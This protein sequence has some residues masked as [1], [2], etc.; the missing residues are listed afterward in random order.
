MSNKKALNFYEVLHLTKTASE[1]EIKQAYRNLA[2]KYH[3]DVNSGDDTKFHS[4]LEAYQVLSD[5]KKRDLYDKFG[6]VEGTSEYDGIFQESFGNG[7]FENIF[8][9]P[10]SGSESRPVEL[11]I[12]VTLEDLFSG[13]TKRYK[14]KRYIKCVKCLGVG[15]E[16]DKDVFYC[17]SC[18]G[19]GKKIIRKSL[20]RG[21]IQQYT[22]TCSVCNGKGQFIKKNCSMCEGKKLIEKEEELKV[23]IE[24]GSNN[25]DQIVF[26]EMSDE[27]PGKKTNDLIFTIEQ[28]P[29]DKYQRQEDDLYMNYQINL[30]EALT[31]FDLDIETI[32]K[33]FIELHVSKVIE[34]GFQYRIKN[35]GM[36]NKKTGKKG[37]LILIFKV[38][39]PK[40]LSEE[41]KEILKEILK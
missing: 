36:P 11:T 3:P 16:S 27:Y 12:R 19:T 15:A 13:C 29:H 18:K 31:G 32:D 2:K 22:S 39:F 41:K 38:K 28:I 10:K 35:E 9:S 33:R 34:P 23:E 26:K 37:H 17:S 5:P 24:K 20:P 7:F 14:Y 6:K 25:A 1:D 4:I 30:I 21:V 40:E 8:F